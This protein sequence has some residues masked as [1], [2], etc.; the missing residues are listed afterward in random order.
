M[1]LRT[2][3]AATTGEEFVVPLLIHEKIVVGDREV[4]INTRDE[5]NYISS[6]VQ[7][8]RLVTYQEGANSYSV[9]VTD[10]EWRPH[11]LIQDGTYWN[12]ICTVTLHSMPK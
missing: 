11:H 9:F 4:T 8:R 6:L 7:D 3:P 1:T 10:Y 12:G 2:Y 5:I